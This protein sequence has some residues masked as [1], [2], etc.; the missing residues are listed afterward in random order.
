MPTRH[1]RREDPRREEHTKEGKSKQRVLLSEAVPS[2]GR[3]PK[4]GAEKENSFSKTP[5]LK[6]ETELE[7][8]GPVALGGPRAIAQLKGV[9]K[10]VSVKPELKEPKRK[11]SQHKKERGFPASATAK[12]RKKINP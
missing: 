12:K 6:K 9:A 11:E 3:Q 2:E 1:E 4:K 5:T 8:E 10:A 7:G